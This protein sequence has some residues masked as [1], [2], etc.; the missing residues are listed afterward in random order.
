[1]IGVLWEL[2]HFHCSWAYQ[3]PPHLRRHIN[4]SLLPYQPD[5]LSSNEILGLAISFH[6]IF[7]H[8]FTC[9]TYISSSLA[10][11]LGYLAFGNSVESFITMELG[12][13]A[14]GVTSRAVYSVAV[15][16]RYYIANIISTTTNMS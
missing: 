9:T 4:P 12:G 3:V 5:W 15:I 1:M 16:L 2:Q 8:I 11:L 6:N 7:V 14:L 13:N 10:A